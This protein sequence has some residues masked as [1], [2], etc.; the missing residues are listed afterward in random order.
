MARAK[1]VRFREKK[2]RRLA[3]SQQLDF[4]FNKVDF[5]VIASVTR[6][7]SAL[8]RVI[9]GKQ[10]ESPRPNIIYSLILILINQ[11]N[12]PL[13]QKSGHR[14]VTFV[15][16]YSIAV[17]LNKFQHSIYQNWRHYRHLVSLS[18]TG[19]NSPQIRQNTR[20]SE[21]LRNTISAIGFLTIWDVKSLFI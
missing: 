4:S 2:G 8:L 15:T 6:S 20:R 10:G 18:Q 14:S 13:A 17:F 21:F 3:P 7:P 16:K 5:T 19:Q 11:G 1:S 9:S 12:A